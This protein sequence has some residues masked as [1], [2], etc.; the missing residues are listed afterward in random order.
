MDHL[1]RG[2]AP[3]PSAAWQHIEDEAKERLSAYLA[4]RRLVDLAG[5]HGWDHSAVG[6]GRVAA[7]DDLPAGLSSPG[8]QARLRQVLP[9]AEIRVPFTLNRGELEDAERGAVD[10]DLDSLDAATQQ[11]AV[12]E[13]RAVF[14][15]WAAASIQG[16]EQSSSH[17]AQKLGDNAE[18]YP[19]VVAGAVDCLRKAGISGPYGLAVGPQ[20]H[21]RIVETTEHGGYLVLD[22]LRRVLDGG[23]VVR[24]AGVDGAF[25]LGM[26]SG[27]LEL[28]LGQDF[29]IGYA[30]H[31]ADT[32]SLYLE[33][34]FTFRV[35]EP[36]S[37]VAITS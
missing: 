13:N 18:R 26:G 33:E 9:L 27:D 19:H 7:I 34:S 22:H 14:H 1:Y 28:T 20:A 36:D 37:A 12:I 23:N 17:P 2:L 8:N 32:V 30:G 29:S 5:P 25:V 10:L 15:G 4:A 35:A 24:S 3:I 21:T 6:M 16:V 31:D 11:A